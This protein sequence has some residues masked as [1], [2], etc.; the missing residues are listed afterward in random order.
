[1]VR[2]AS[3]YGP[4]LRRRGDEIISQGAHPAENA[5]QSKGGGWSDE[6][7]CHALDV[8]FSMVIRVRDKL[9]PTR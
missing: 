8:N 2:A 1:L 7:I 9:R 3:A 5:D 6:A 4:L